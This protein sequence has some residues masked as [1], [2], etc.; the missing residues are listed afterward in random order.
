MFQS[1]MTSRP[2]PASRV[3][4]TVIAPGTHE[5]R[6]SLKHPGA[7]TLRSPSPGGVSAPSSSYSR[8]GLIATKF[9]THISVLF[10]D[11]GAKLHK[12]FRRG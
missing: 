6:S 2:S 10:M 9:D 3:V 4:L 12:E 8:H 7:P 5:G 11:A 1:I